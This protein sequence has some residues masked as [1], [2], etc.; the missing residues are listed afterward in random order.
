MIDV[1]IIETNKETSASLSYLIRKAGADVKILSVINTID[2][3]I[4]YFK[5]NSYEIDLLFLDTQFYN[6]YPQEL[7]SLKLVNVPVVIMGESEHNF[8]NTLNSP[9]VLINYLLKPV[10][11]DKVKKALFKYSQLKDCFNSHNEIQ[12]HSVDAGDTKKNYRTRLLVKKA[13]FY[14]YTRVED[15]ACIFTDFKIV[16]I[17]DVHNNKYITLYKSLS[18]LEDELDPNMFFRANRKFIIN[19]H[20]IAR[21]KSIDKVKLSVKL[22]VPMEDIVI[23]QLMTPKF[24]AWINEEKLCGL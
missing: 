3:A 16:F 2:Q 10:N 13:G 17:L 24:K 14:Q 19:I 5:N 12:N 20:S 4:D 15:I 7:L 6:T 21:F 9:F 23:S 8:I 22:I 11:E 18:V 1:L